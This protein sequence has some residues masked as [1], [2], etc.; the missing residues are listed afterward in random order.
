MQ[1]QMP[2][3]TIGG[4]S[5]GV[6]MGVLEGTPTHTVMNRAKGAVQAYAGN[7]S[8]TGQNENPY[9]WINSSSLFVQIGQ[10]DPTNG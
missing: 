1:T 5:P 7:Q 6:V 8:K 3:C 9:S 4:N 10:M 2:D